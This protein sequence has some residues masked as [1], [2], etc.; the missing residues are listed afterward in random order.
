MHNSSHVTLLTRTYMHHTE[1]KWNRQMYCFRM[2]HGT[3]WQSS[4]NKRKRSI[5][6]CVMEALC[7]KREGKNSIWSDVLNIDSFV[8]SYHTGQYGQQQHTPSKGKPV[9]AIHNRCR[10]SCCYCHKHT[11][12]LVH[13]AG[14]KHKMPYHCGQHYTLP[15]GHT[16]PCCKGC[17]LKK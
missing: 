6:C 17:W 7:V 12:W 11:V 4:A 8:N 1:C 15:L 10:M 5:R 3:Y 13:S 2:S 9:F 16:G 14:G